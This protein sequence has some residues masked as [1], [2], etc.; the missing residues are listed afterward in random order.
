MDELIKELERFGD[1]TSSFALLDVVVV[2]A[3]S[4]TLW[5]IYAERLLQRLEG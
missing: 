2:F 1:L 4:L 5:R 3:L